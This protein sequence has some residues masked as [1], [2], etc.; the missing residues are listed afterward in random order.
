MTNVLLLQE[1]FEEV[2]ARLVYRL[3]ND[4]KLAEEAS[5]DAMDKNTYHMYLGYG[6]HAKEMLALIESMQEPEVCGTCETPLTNP[7]RVYRFY[8]NECGNE[9]RKSE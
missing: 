5:N 2:K 8:C 6:Q 9:R 7:D 4:L 1:V 3:G